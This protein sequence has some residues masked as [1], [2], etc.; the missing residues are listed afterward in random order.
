MTLVNLLLLRSSS[1]FALQVIWGEGGVSGFSFRKFFS[2]ERSQL[3]EFLTDL[4]SGFMR[5]LLRRGV[6]HSF[7][8][9]AYEILR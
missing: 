9:I 3:N 6:Y 2:F 5:K 8:N 4:L 7:E 1:F